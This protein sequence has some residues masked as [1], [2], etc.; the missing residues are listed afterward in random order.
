M[1]SQFKKL[2]GY[3][4]LKSVLGY[5]A[6]LSFLGL[7][8]QWAF[9]D[10]NPWGGGSSSIDP[11]NLQKTISGDTTGTL[12]TVSVVVGTFLLLGGVSVLYKVLNRDSDERREHGNS[13]ITLL[14]A[15]L[16]AVVGIVLLGIAWKGLSYSA[17]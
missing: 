12:K 1:M 16:C 15:G 5:G 11:G 4:T 14:I 6:V 17:S 8:P 2:C 9:A 3:L 13:V 10:S 7:L